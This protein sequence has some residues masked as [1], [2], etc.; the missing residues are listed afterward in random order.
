MK[1]RE[2]REQT[3]TDYLFSDISN[4][5]GAVFIHNGKQCDARKADERLSAKLDCAGEK[6]KNADQ[7]IERYTTKSCLSSKKYVTRFSDGHGYAVSVHLH[8]KLEESAWRFP[9]QLNNTQTRG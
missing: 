7:F 9:L 3:K 2:L 6:M 1:A 8:G 5:K 4:V